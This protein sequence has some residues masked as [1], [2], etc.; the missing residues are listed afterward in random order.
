MD[1]KNASQMYQPS[2]QSFLSDS[3]MAGSSR[4]RKAYIWL[5][6]LFLLLVPATDSLAVTV[7]IAHQWGTAAQPHKGL[8]AAADAFMAEHPDIKIEILRLVNEEKFITQVLGGA[9]ADLQFVDGPLVSSYALQ[10]F[11]TPL[12]SRIKAAGVNMADFVPP[13][14]R[15]NVWE[16]DIWALPIGADPNFALIWNKDMFNDVGLNPDQGPTTIADLEDFHKKLT[17]YNDTRL[18]QI[19]IAPWDVYSEPN[20]MY[21]WGWTFG[22]SFFDPAT[23]QVTA[24]HPAN[25]KALE[26][27]RG[28]YQRYYSD[29]RA[30]NTG[31][32]VGITLGPKWF[33]ARKVA[34]RYSVTGELFDFLKNDPSLSIGIGKMPYLPESGN[35][36]PAWTGGWCVAIPQGAKNADA[37]WQFLRYITT[38]RKG[39]TV[40]AETSGW[41][42]GYLRT[43]VFSEKFAKDPWLSHYMNILL[44]ASNQRPAIPVQRTY[45]A[46]LTQA[47]QDVFAGKNQPQAALQVVSERVAADLAKAMAAKK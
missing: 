37:A 14:W 11:I 24:H 27:L 25:V 21:T 13:T 16:G 47:V 35:K 28:Y 23:R 40:F 19:G 1:Y 3:N 6:L 22:G 17:K 41:F 31:M 32:A 46:E 38:D 29:L 20:T 30:M 5:L 43:P 45:W 33:S 4:H 7:T 12:T 9:P 36:N 44:E 34:M 2:I 39:V 15:Q 42:P 26:W 10:G 18:Q 8:V